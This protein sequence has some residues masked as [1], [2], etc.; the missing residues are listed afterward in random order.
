M[1]FTAM[2]E[3]IAAIEPTTPKPKRPKDRS[4]P[5]ARINDP[6]GHGIDFMYPDTLTEGVNYCRSRCR[7]GAHVASL[8]GLADVLVRSR[9]GLER[10]RPACPRLGSAAR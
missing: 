3:K 6:K 10:R 1:T 8:S 7:K 5:C 2:L 9:S 4:A